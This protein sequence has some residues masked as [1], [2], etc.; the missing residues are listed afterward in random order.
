MIRFVLEGVCLRVSS[1]MLKLVLFYNIV[2]ITRICNWK[3]NCDLL[4]LNQVC[5]L[6]I[7]LINIID[8]YLSVIMV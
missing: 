3:F 1:L 4:V 7:C 6:R 8:L 5:S 2:S